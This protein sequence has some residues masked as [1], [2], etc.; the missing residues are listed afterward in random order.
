MEF[1]NAVS[2]PKKRDIMPH[3][4]DACEMPTIASMLYEDDA[5][6]P[7]TQERWLAIT[8]SV[9]HQVEEFQNKIKCDLLNL[10]EKPRQ[11]WYLPP[12]KKVIQDQQAQ[13]TSDN[14]DFNILEAASSLFVCDQYGCKKPVGYRVLFDHSHLNGLKWSSVIASIQHEAA[15]K[16]TVMMVLKALDLPDDTSLTA[17]E[18]MDGRLTCLCGHP[19]FLNPLTFT[20]LVICLS[21]IA[22]YFKFHWM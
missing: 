11:H 8:H 14:D 13:N 7:V 9:P 3:Y 19:D 4:I 20:S 12:A 16:P 17:M 21:Y 1:V 15:I 2:D 10:L 18:A 22:P 5:Q 6:I